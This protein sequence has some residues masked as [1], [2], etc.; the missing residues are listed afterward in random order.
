MVARTVHTLD[1][2]LSRLRA[3]AIAENRAGMARF[4][5]DVDAALGVSMPNIRA[6]AKA[7]A[8]DHHLAEQLWR[9][10]IHE[11]RILASLVDDPKLVTREQMDRWVVDLNSWDVCGNLFDRTPYAGEKIFRWSTREEEFVKRAAFALTAWRSVHDKKEPHYTKG[12]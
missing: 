9:S 4:G 10:G 6:T 5:I 2:A 7:I 3:H 1:Q 8:K 11:A 12:T